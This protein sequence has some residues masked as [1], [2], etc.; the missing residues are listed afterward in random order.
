MDAA[1]A[2]ELRK[3]LEEQS[4]WRQA[5]AVCD[6]RQP[7]TD[8]DLAELEA[9]GDNI[10]YYAREEQRRPIGG[11]SALVTCRMIKRLIAG[12]W[13][14]S[15]ERDSVQYLDGGTFASTPKVRSDDRHEAD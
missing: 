6:G 4:H 5:E 7:P 3:R 10:R 2:E 15:Y 9:T 12:R 13:E 14:T 8:P 1:G 11:R